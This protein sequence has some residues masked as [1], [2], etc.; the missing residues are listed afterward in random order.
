[1]RSPPHATDVGMG[2]NFGNSKPYTRPKLI[3]RRA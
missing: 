1:M 3:E 2:G